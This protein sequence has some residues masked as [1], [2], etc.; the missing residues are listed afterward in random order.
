[1]VAAYHAEQE[2]V[3]R[4]SQVAGLPRVFAQ[5]YNYLYV[6]ALKPLK[7]SQSGSMFDIELATR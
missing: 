7:L 2:K 1:M 3:Q 4:L 5:H 6:Q